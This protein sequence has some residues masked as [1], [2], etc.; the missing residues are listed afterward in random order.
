MD[1]KTHCRFYFINSMT[2]AITSIQSYHQSLIS[3]TCSTFKCTLSTLNKTIY[4]DF[5]N[6]YK[7]QT[8]KVEND[9]C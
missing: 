3:L 4:D 1:L 6:F 7:T 2:T 5:H 9:K 8:A